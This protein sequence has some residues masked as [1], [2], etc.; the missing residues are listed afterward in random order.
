M[1]SVCVPSSVRQKLVDNE[2]FCLL[3]RSREFLAEHYDSALTLSDA[4]DVACLSPFHFHRLFQRAFGETP[5][6]FLTRRRLEH[7]MTLLRQGRTVSEA[8]IEVGYGSPSSFSALFERHIGER[9][10]EFRRV[11]AIPEH[12][13]LR[14]VPGCFRFAMMSPMSL[15]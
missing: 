15:H 13:F 5:H 14:N 4:A 7:A 12:W 1:A 3:A 8:C 10:S 9:P 6:D 11:Y 2:T